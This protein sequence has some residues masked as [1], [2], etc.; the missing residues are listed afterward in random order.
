MIVINAIIETI[1]DFMIII[2]I[3]L[4]LNYLFNKDFKKLINKIK[5]IAFS[6]Q[7]KKATLIQKTLYNYFFTNN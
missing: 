6:R 5:K 7:T 1:R 3:T 4:I 2:I